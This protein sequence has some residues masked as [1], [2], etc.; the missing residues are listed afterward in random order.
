MKKIAPLLLLF[1][2]AVLAS[3]DGGKES[4][5]P[6]HPQVKKTHA[7]IIEEIAMMRP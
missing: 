7:Q 2:I 1:G 6:F 4:K 3:P 5:K